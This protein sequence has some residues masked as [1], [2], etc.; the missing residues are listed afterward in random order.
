M[1]ETNTYFVISEE[2]AVFFRGGF[3]GLGKRS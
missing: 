1:I 2:R 3:P